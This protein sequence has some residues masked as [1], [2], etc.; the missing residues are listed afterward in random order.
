[1]G[2]S[3]PPCWAWL[4]AS[5]SHCALCTHTQNTHPSAQRRPALPRGG[6]RAPHWPFCTP[7]IPTPQDR[8]CTSVLQACGSPGLRGAPT[9]RWGK[10]AR[11]PGKGLQNSPPRFHCVTLGKSLSS[12]EARFPS[13]TRRI[14]QLQRERK[15][16]FSSLDAGH[17]L[18]TC[19]IPPLPFI[20]TASPWLP[21][22]AHGD[23]DL[24]SQLVGGRAGT[25]AGSV[26]FLSESLGCL[27]LPQCPRPD[28]CQAGLL[29]SLRRSL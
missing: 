8:H 1:M 24:P 13:S 16:L 21:C 7:G 14:L 20:L 6:R 4:V 11:G 26:T 22:Q 9:R 18:N 2:P 15:R 25:D 28:A 5:H 3:F 17:L 29:P 19:C 23:R 12:S 10:Q 27:G